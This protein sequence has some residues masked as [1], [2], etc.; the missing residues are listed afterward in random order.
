MLIVKTGLHVDVSEHKNISIALNQI[1]D[2]N[3]LWNEYSEN[4]IKNVKKFY[5]WK[6]HTEKYLFEVDKI[7]KAQSK[8][9]NTFAETGRKLLD[10]Q[11]LIV[12][13]IDYTLIGDDLL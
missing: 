8:V 4:G 6:A 12:T 1:L 11:K 10:M 9:Q 3:K 2:N 7:L 5:S 13:D